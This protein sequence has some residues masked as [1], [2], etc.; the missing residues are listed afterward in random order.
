MDPPVFVKH[1]MPG[2]TRGCYTFRVIIIIIVIVVVVIII[3]LVV[4]TRGCSA[5]NP[6]KGERFVLRED[7][8]VEWR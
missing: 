8:R 2:D 7:V 5:K 4:G 1:R 3:I 6:R